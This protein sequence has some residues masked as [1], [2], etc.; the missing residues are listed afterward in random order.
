MRPRGLQLSMLRLRFFRRRRFAF[1]MLFA[2]SGVTGQTLF[3]QSSQSDGMAEQIQKLREALTRTQEQLDQSRRDMDALRKQ[4]DALQ[5]A[6][7]TAGT[8]PQATPPLEDLREQL[9][10]HSSEIATEE[11]TKVETESKFPLKLSGLLL[12]NGFVNTRQVDVAAT[13]SIALAGSG[14]TGASVRQTV[15][16]LDARGPHLLGAASHADL[17]VDFYGN[18]SYSSSPTAD[19][20]GY[21]SSFNYNSFPLRLRTAHATLDWDHTQAFFSLDRTILNPDSPTSLTALA[22]PALAW[23]GNLW[24][25]NPQVGVTHDVSLGDAKELRLQAAVIDVADAPLLPSYLSIAQVPAGPLASTAEQSRWPGSEVRI[26][27]MGPGFGSK[28]ENGAH[29]GVGG[30]FAPHRTADGYRFDAW[31]AT[32]D[33]HLPLPLHLEF[34]GS[35]YRGRAL[36]GLGGGGF[37]DYVAYIEPPYF[38]YRVPDDIGGWSQLKEKISERL[39]FNAAFGL[40]ELTAGQLRPYAGASSAAYLNLARNQTFT[41]NVIYSPSAYLLF[42]LEYR[43]LESSPVTGPNA[44][45][46][47]IGLGAGYKF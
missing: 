1:A 37:K 8:T 25:W 36:G 10:L 24:A 32:L 16:G 11:Q 7:D 41:G 45:S 42:S 43:H 26:A 47:I 28:P 44:T 14:S 13:P 27:F 2:L 9:A 29:F 30:F 46:N 20:A 5:Q 6:A 21:S 12:F 22:E 18:A 17:R 15:L 19:A 4:L 39:E 40:D 33:Y 35:V 38:Y 31:A 23:S 3:A 34:S